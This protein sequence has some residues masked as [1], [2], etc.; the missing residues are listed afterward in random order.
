MVYRPKEEYEAWLKKDPILRFEAT[1]R[2]M[3][4]LDD[5][6]IVAIKKEIEDKVAAAVNFAEESP[7]PEPDELLQDV[8]T[9]AAVAA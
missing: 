7:F 3:G 2:D 6:K 1:L 8:Y 9:G 5:A 4:I